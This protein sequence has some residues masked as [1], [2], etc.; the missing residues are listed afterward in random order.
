VL[1][2]E[3]QEDVSYLDES[4][5]KVGD[6]LRELERTVIRISVPLKGVLS[7]FSFKLGWTLVAADSSY[8]QWAASII[9]FSL[10]C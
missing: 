2:A 5:T 8:V 3:I 1:I 7:Q 9:V 10:G 6:E 4:I